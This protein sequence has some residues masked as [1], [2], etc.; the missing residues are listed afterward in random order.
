MTL[1][2]SVRSSFAVLLCIIFTGG[3]VFVLHTVPVSVLNQDRDCVSCRIQNG[4]GR[5]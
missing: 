4:A 2:V 1:S 5:V 3:T